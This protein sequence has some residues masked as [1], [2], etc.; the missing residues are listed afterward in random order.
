MHTRPA[1]GRRPSP[2][3]DAKECFDLDAALSGHGIYAAGGARG[4][5]AREPV[6][7][8]DTGVM[9]ISAGNGWP[10]TRKS[11]A[12]ASAP[13]LPLASFT[14]SGWLART[15][16][17]C[18]LPEVLSNA[19]VSP[20]RAALMLEPPWSETADAEIPAWA[21]PSNAS[22][23]SAI[24]PAKAVLTG[25]SFDLSRSGAV[26]PISGYQNPP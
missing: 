3:R 6:A 1:D 15:S 2:D 23:S 17:A 13:G 9:P 11:A 8:A 12:G 4:W 16:S 5:L 22:I 24:R 25:S 7:L 14:G 20:W 19:I 10:I 26:K 18:A 21:K